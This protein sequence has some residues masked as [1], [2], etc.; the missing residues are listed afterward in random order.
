MLKKRPGLSSP[1]YDKAF[2]DIDDVDHMA[3][4]VQKRAVE[5]SERS[6]AGLLRALDHVA[7]LEEDA[8]DDIVIDPELVD[9][10]AER[11][12]ATDDDLIAGARPELEK[13]LQGSDRG[14]RQRA[15]YALVRFDGP[16]SPLV[17]GGLEGPPDDQIAVL[18]A[19]ADPLHEADPTED[20]IVIATSR[21]RFPVMPP[22]LLPLLRPLLTP[23]AVAR[24]RGEDGAAVSDSMRVLLLVLRIDREAAGSDVDALLLAAAEAEEFR[25]LLHD[26]LTGG[27]LAGV[28]LPVSPSIRE[29]FE[30][31]A[32]SIERSRHA[33][34]PSRTEMAELGLLAGLVGRDEAIA[35]RTVAIFD[36]IGNKALSSV[37]VPF[38]GLLVASIDLLG[39]DELAKIAGFMV[40]EIEERLPA[41]AAAWVRLDPA[42][43][44]D[45]ARRF[46]EGDRARVERRWLAAARAHLAFPGRRPEIAA[47]IP[48]TA[49]GAALGDAP[50]EVARPILESL[51]RKARNGAELLSAVASASARR[52]RAV[53]GAVLEKLRD[54]PFRVDAKLEALLVPLMGPENEDAV[55]TEIDGENPFRDR[56]EA[57][58]RALA[59]ALAPPA[60]TQTKTKAPAKTK[61]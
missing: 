25:P 36:L 59:T 56:R 47:L 7:H 15:R 11:E 13:W 6:V 39:P 49:L 19:L 42:K 35:R 50:P 22:T 44:K 18:R 40:S 14:R 53:L 45:L 5:D 2:P 10:I 38:A 20:W 30:R 23:K 34:L 27:R 12:R 61:K 48:E 3:Y 60:K 54:T 55:Q 8:I 26:E 43:A 1:T 28:R 41:A 29:R 31:G 32:A 17:A 37:V 9:S 58:A 46:H 16:A 4:E 52:E 24:R 21:L 33:G 51:V 57:L